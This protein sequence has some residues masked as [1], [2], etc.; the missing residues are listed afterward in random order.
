MRFG[1][2]PRLARA[3]ILSV[4]AL[5]LGFGVGLV[6]AQPPSAVD[7]LG[8]LAA[9]ATGISDWWLFATLV[10]L[11]GL[12]HIFP[13]SS[14]EHRQAY[15]VSLPFFIA[16]TVL[17][18]PLPLFVLIVVVHLA[19]WVRRPQRSWFAQAFNLAVYVLSAGSAHAIYVSIWSVDRG[20]IDLTATE[21]LLAGCAAVITFG[22]LN[23]ALVS[24]VIWVGNR[25]P[26][27]R[28]QL[29]F[30]AE[31][32]FIDSAL[33][34]LGLPLARLGLDAPWALALGATPVLLVHRA[35]DLPNIRAQARRDHL[36]QLA[37][38]AAFE[39]A[40]SRELSRA[41]HFGRPLALAVLEIAGFDQ[42]VAKHGRQA[43]DVLLRDAARLLE[44]AARAYDV[45]ARLDSAQFGLLLPET[46]AAGGR[47]M[48]EHVRRTLT[49]RGFDVASSIEQI[50]VRLR[51][52][53]AAVQSD[54][55]TVQ[56][57]IELAYAG[58]ARSSDEHTGELSALASPMPAAPRPAA[59]TPAA[60]VAAAPAASRVRSSA[61]QP[62]PPGDTP[63]LATRALLLAVSAMA[64][65]VILTAVPALPAI[66][67]LPL[68]F[69][70]LLVGLGELLSLQLFDRS[71]F[72]ISVAPCL[73]AG[74]LMGVPGVALAAPMSAI[75]RG[76]YRRTRWYKV[77]F[78]A[79][80]YVVAGAGA[81]S[82]FQALVPALD[83]HDLPLLLLAAAV[84]G[85]AYYGHTLLVAAIMAL[86]SRSSLVGL[87][88]EHFRWL[89]PQ[90]LVL[91]VMGLFL[92][93]GY[94][95]FGVLGAAVFALPPLMLRVVSKQYVD[96][97]L[98]NVRQLRELNHQLTHQAFHDPLT[99]LA[100]R[101]RLTDRVQHALGRA[102]RHDEELVVLFIDLDNFKA[103]NDSLGHAVGDQLLI[104][105][106]ERIRG[107]LR[108]V[109]TPARLGGDEFAVLLEDVVEPGE[110]MQVANRILESLQLPFVLADKE[111]FSNA[112]IGIAF[113]HPGETDAD[114]LL[115]NADVAMYAAKSCGK[116]R[117]EVF[118]SRLHTEVLR[119]LALEAD[120]R[121]A[122][123][124]NEFVIYYQP[125][126]RLDSGDVSGFEA[127]VRWQHPERGLVPPGEFIASAES[128][129][130][131]VPIGRWVLR[132][133]CQQV[134]R[135]QTAYAGAERLSISINLSARQLQDA[136]IVDDVADALAASGL[137]PSALVLE[138]TETLLMQDV[139]ATVQRLRQLKALGVRLAIDDFGTG[140]SSLSYLRRFPVDVLKIDR[141]FVSGVGDGSEDAVLTEAIVM[142]A[143][144]LRL[145][146]VAEG[147][148]EPEQ[149][150]FLRR[151]AC[152]LGQGYYFARPLPVSELEDLLERT[153]V[154]Q[155]QMG[156]VHAVGLAA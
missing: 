156:K 7:G 144:T 37:S 133:A 2:L 104:N 65:A 81:A 143:H 126:V 136:C 110:A 90:Y 91:S 30:E 82:I 67:L 72:S 84:A 80:T 76:V 23:R 70:A 18:A 99:N 33:L 9:R 113:S 95:Q 17:L 45:P 121:A 117:V 151:L 122:V 107:C 28:Q 5:A 135:W 60:P 71:A 42:I 13:V 96:R 12:A 27:S 134:R 114:E 40:C 125:T 61:S 127:L 149:L 69:F 153:L 22:T 59:Q 35:L 89:W 88:L 137:E 100:N 39:D 105:V 24:M 139:E 19:E 112:S 109:D 132:E 94:T 41:R 64:A 119:R 129:G 103:V 154:A 130:L 47:S 141:S 108:A 123:E 146:V 3:Y 26:P 115:R 63:S 16:A 138:I 49:E 34:V 120:L 77:L 1:S 36:T 102:A 106:S 31:S 54:A 52:G 14:V 55:M 93:L 155:V 68:V 6:G 87:W 79:S 111:V 32:L 101:A 53:V 148:E 140:Y 48:V 21:G 131:I 97:T 92:A 43:A 62:A 152:D 44:Q 57:L 38:A 128:S 8:G 10:C 50:T 74:I 46:D 11:A 75:V 20:A 147:I 29:L 85:V 86:E 25:I 124:R 4:C 83:A 98:D 150:A 66:E 51:A 73:A 145:K 15:H 118:E 142:L 78:N 58:L 56:Q 116:G